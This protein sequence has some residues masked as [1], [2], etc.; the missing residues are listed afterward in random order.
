[1]VKW[2]FSNNLI[3]YAEALEYMDAKVQDIYHNNTQEEIWFLEHPDI[4]TAGVSAKQSDLLDKNIALINTGRGGQITYHGPNMRIIYAM[5]NL[6]SRNLCD[7]RQYIKNLEEWVINS[8]EQVNIKAHTI[9][10]KIGIW[11]TDSSNK[12]KQYKIAAIGVRVRKWVTY[13]GIAINY[14]PDLN[15]FKSIIPCGIS[16]DNYSV[17]SIKN[18]NKDITK[19]DLDFILKEEF[20]KIF[21]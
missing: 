21:S 14:D 18:L 17:T 6:K 4:Y 19:Q 12:N 7:I 10:G 1:M 2:K 16:D 13:H 3:S 5:L 20:Q 15:K 9:E 11:V 8:L